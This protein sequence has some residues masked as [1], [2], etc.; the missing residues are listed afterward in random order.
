MLRLGYSALGPGT[1]LAPHHGMTNGQL[2]LHTGLFVPVA[3]GDGGHCAGIRVGNETRAWREGGTLFFDDSFEHEAW[4]RCEQERVVV[5]VVIV[6]P[7][8]VG[9]LVRPA[10]AASGQGPGH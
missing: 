8:L 4:N 10:G 7:D 9:K 1:H 3:A 6:H 2:K 5:Q